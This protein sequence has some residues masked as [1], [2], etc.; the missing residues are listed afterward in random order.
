M[1]EWIPNVQNTL[2]KEWEA[3]SAKIVLPEN[4]S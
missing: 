1:G 3:L 2:Q 4:T